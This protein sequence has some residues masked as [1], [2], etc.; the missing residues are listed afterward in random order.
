MFTAS[1]LKPSHSSADVAPPELVP[2]SLCSQLDLDGRLKV[3]PPFLRPRYLD[4]HRRYWPGVDS[5]SDARRLFTERREAEARARDHA[6]A[7]ERRLLRLISCSG[8]RW[9]GCPGGPQFLHGMTYGEAVPRLSL[10]VLGVSTRGRPW[11]RMC[12]TTGA[13]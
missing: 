10:T 8:L 4:H 12:L 1:P 3:G 2:L 6:A 9:G 11:W 13:T 5:P 7:V